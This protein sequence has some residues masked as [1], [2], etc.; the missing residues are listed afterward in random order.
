MAI[1]PIRSEAGRELVERDFVAISFSW[2]LQRHEKTKSLETE[3][4]PY[5]AYFKANL[6]EEASF[7]LSALFHTHT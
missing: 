4:G 2:Q 6:G 3:S 1:Q 5:T 7:K